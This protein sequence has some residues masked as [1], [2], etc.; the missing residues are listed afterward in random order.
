MVLL[1]YLLKK[2][3]VVIGVTSTE[4]NFKVFHSVSRQ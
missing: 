3:E 1:G 4:E 2:F